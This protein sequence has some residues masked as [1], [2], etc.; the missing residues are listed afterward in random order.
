[1]SNHSGL[2]LIVSGPSGVGK[3]TICNALLEKYPG[4]YALSVSATS[5]NPRGEEQDGREYFFRTREEFEK[6]IEEGMLL[7]YANYT[8]NY[9][10]TPRQWVEERMREGI[11]VILEIDYQGGFQI[12]NKLPDTLM[13]FIMPPN[14][15]ELLARLKGRGTETQ[16]Q[17]LRRLEKAEEEMAVAER[18]DYIIVNE[19]VEKSV[20]MLHNIVSYEKKKI[21]GEL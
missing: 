4:E 11:N 9:Y 19:D 21:T 15:D 3:G 2:L 5:R 20:E 7:E 10:G 16:E 8:G 6:M 12:K 14:V 17:I 13:I 1:M 18:Y